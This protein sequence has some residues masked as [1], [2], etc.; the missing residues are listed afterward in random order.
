MVVGDDDGGDDGD[1][2]GGGGIFQKRNHSQRWQS[3]ILLINQSLNQE[4]LVFYNAESY[5]LAKVSSLY[6]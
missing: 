1:V 4:D 2:K 5:T 6:L 3:P